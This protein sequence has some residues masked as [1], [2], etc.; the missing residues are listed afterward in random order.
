IILPHAS[1]LENGLPAL[2]WAV[3]RAALFLAAMIIAGSRI[4]PPLMTYIARLNSREFFL[5]TV[6]AI[7][8]GIGYATY[9]VG[10]SFAFGAFVAGLVLSESDHSHQALSDIIPLRDI[11]S[12]LF[13]VSVGM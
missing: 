9:L 7:G 2:G 5:V 8:L 11:S 10:L 4:L 12:L 1:N 6:T 13:F 3:L